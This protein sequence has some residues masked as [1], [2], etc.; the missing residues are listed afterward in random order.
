MGSGE[1]KGIFRIGVL[2][3]SADNVF[4]LRNRTV[5]I[6]HQL[7]ADTAER[8]RRFILAWRGRRSGKPKYTGVRLT[9]LFKARKKH[10]LF[11]GSADM[12]K[13]EEL[14]A[15]IKKAQKTETGLAV[16]LWKNPDPEEGRPLYSLVIDVSKDAEDQPRRK[17]RAIEPDDEEDKDEDDEDEEEAEDDEELPF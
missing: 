2:S 1:V 8:Y 5:T 16:F 15:I 7:P 9:G 17:Q 4:T 11:V 6:Q 14:V 13:V 10:G 12:D 3:V